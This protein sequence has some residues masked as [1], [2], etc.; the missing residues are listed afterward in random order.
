MSIKS[1]DYLHGFLE[2][3]SVI[4]VGPA[5][6]I[7]KL[8]NGSAIDSY[9]VVIRI[10]KGFP[11]DNKSYDKIGKKTTILSTTLKSYE[12]PYENGK[13][14]YMQNNFCDNNFN[15]MVDDNVKLIFP[16]PIKKRPFSKF[17]QRFHD[18]FILPV[19]LDIF[20]N[21]IEVDEYEK[22]QHD[23]YKNNTTNPSIFLMTL[24]TVLKSNLK[25]LAITGFDFRKGG[26][27]TNYKSE[28]F[29]RLSKKFTTNVNCH[30]FDK[31]Y[32][33]F[34]NLYKTNKKIHVDEYFYD[35]YLKENNYE[36]RLL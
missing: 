14:R 3:K 34:I 20:E 19:S 8:N 5:S 11:V 27:V 1:I 10:K 9:D 35:S 31:E 30:N 22:Y 29:D 28:L 16:Y 33:Y 26:Y 6:Y 2:N 13:Y 15:L 7:T 21:I 32:E 12:Q 4:I 23:I 24:I 18:K 36:K 25:K 17:H